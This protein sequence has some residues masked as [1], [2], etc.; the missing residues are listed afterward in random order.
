MDRIAVF[1]RTE[2]VI[3]LYNFLDKHTSRDCN[4]ASA[5]PAVYTS[6]HSLEE[7]F[8]WHGKISN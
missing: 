5:Y 8:N 1:D 4:V 7:S 2:K 3:T 6:V